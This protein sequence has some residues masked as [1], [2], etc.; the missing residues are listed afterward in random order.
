MT[1]R[2]RVEMALR[3]EEPDR[4]PLDLGASGQTG[5]NASVLYS[6]RRELGLEEKPIDICEP[7]QLLGQIDEDLRKALGIDTVALWNP[8]TMFGTRFG[9]WTDWKMPDGTPVNM[10]GNFQYTEADEGGLL[11]YPQGD[12]TAAPSVRLPEGGTFFDNI[13]RAPAFDEGDLDPLR[14]FQNL[15]GTYSDE[16][17]RFIENSCNELYE[18]TDCAIH[19]NFNGGGFGD[20][21]IIPGPWEKQPRGIRK[22]EDWYMAHYIHPEYLKDLFAWQTELAF[23]NL[24]ILKEA[25]GDKITTINISCTD[26]GSQAGEMM[27]VEHFR[28][29]YK[30]HY[31]ALNSW[32]HE[33]TE[34]YSHFHCCGSIVNFLP[35]FVESGFDVFNPV[36][37]SAAGMDG[38]EL[39]EN[40]G[41]KL[42]FWGGGV[43]TQK[44]LPFGTPDEVRKEVRERL[45]ILS[46]GGGF[47]FNTIHNI[48]GNTPVENV[49]AMFEEVKSFNAG[50]S[51]G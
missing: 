38:H 8:G 46:P 26:F 28:E 24:E 12:R 18:K 32:V 25:L 23:K 29:F 41:D 22:L 9:S 51:E 4:V 20:A 19:F 40:Y 13:D 45:E 15:Y 43:D 5:I 37:L 6:L 48:V 17:A 21:A 42:T 36:Q 1:S 16:D 30:D 2:E 35:E 44:T 31:I 33:N 47:V 10:P 50:T 39:K 34:W 3:H 27:S 7:F 11:V 14:D 49:I